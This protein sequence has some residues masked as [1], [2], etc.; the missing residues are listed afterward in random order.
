M[1]EDTI[2]SYFGNAAHLEIITI[3]S[4]DDPESVIPPVLYL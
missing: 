1:C 2:V 3:E 4:R